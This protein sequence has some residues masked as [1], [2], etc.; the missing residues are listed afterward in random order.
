[1]TAQKEDY[2]QYFPSTLFACLLLTHLEN[3]GFEVSYPRSTKHVFIS[4]YLTQYLP[5]VSWKRD[6][7]IRTSTSVFYPL[8][9]MIPTDFRL[10]VVSNFVDGVE[11]GKIHARARRS[12]AKRSPRVTSPRV[13]A[14]I[15][16]V[17]RPTP[18]SKLETTHGPNRF[19]RKSVNSGRSRG[20][21]NIISDKRLARLSFTT[22]LMV[23]TFF[24][25]SCT[26]RNMTTWRAANC[27]TF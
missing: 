25:S 4:L 24:L 16:I 26:Y 20:K 22:I 11:A 8:F 12:D 6:H 13:R 7:S 9:N 27:E 15:S 21:L 1:M 23:E 5:S 19:W 17:H 14:C 10:R 2:N 3:Y 18:L